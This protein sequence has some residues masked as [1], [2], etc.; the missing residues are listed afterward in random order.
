[1]VLS[2][3]QPSFVCG[4]IVVGATMV[5]LLVI[6]FDEVGFMVVEAIVVGLLVMGFIEVG[7][8]VAGATVV[9]LMV[10][11]FVIFSTRPPNKM[12]R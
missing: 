10:M 5:G 9:G 4:F 8:I 6:G 11:G 2:G 3:K 7:F 1:V 12:T